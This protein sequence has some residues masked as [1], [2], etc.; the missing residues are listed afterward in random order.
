MIKAGMNVGHNGTVI[1]PNNAITIIVIGF[2]E[3]PHR[4]GSSH[5][6]VEH[7]TIGAIVNIKTKH[8]RLR[9]IRIILL[10]HT[11][12]SNHLHQ[13]PLPQE[14]V[15]WLERIHILHSKLHVPQDGSN[16]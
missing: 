12:E 14:A 16:S 6:T 7:A 4:D 15:L 1:K 8:I 13:L 9:F 11:T 10:K 5:T 2:M 3:P